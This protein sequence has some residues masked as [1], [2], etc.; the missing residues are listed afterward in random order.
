M[1]LSSF[2]FSTTHKNLWAQLS[3]AATTGQSKRE[4]KENRRN[5]SKFEKKNVFTTK[6][7]AH[8][9]HE[10]KLSCTTLNKYESIGNSSRNT[11]AV[12]R[13]NLNHSNSQKCWIFFVCFDYVVKFNRKYHQI[14]KKKKINRFLIWFRD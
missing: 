1:S 14:V 2:N 7:Q 13:N 5:L 9:I 10:A 8:Q 6:G 3:E 11:N 4:K 12:N